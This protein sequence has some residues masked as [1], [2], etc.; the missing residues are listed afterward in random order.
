MKYTKQVH[1][2]PVK[3]STV[4]GG[5]MGSQGS[6]TTIK[7]KH[8]ISKSTGKTSHPAG[9]SSTKGAKKFNHG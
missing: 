8:S 4:A 7:P 6:S 3:A 1:A 2:Q 9:K 5:H